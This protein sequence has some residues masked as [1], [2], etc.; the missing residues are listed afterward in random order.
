MVTDVNADW[1]VIGAN[2]TL[3]TTRWV[4]YYISRREN[5]VFV[6]IALKDLQEVHIE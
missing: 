1:A 5:G 6:Y 3:Y 4:R 2:P